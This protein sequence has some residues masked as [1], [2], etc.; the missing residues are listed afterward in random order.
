MRRFPRWRPTHGTQV[1]AAQEHQKRRR[2]ERHTGGIRRDARENESSDLE[3]LV[4][5]NEAAS[6]PVEDL[7]PVAAPA[8]ERKQ[9]AIVR[10]EFVAR[11]N[12][13]AEAVVAAAEIDGLGREVDPHRRRKRQHEGISARTI[14]AT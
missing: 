6:I 14:A 2:V 7:D 9:M 13:G 10:V 12:E 1:Y 8:D 11:A 4:Y 3:A 5:E